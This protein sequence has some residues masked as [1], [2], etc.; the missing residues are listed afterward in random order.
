MTAWEQAIALSSQDWHLGLWE[1][2]SLQAEKWLLSNA[3][4]CTRLACRPPCATTRLLSRYGGLCLL[5]LSMLV[6]A[7]LAS[8]PVTFMHACQ[9]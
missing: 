8:P 6:F 3:T 5:M 7:G 9:V 1:F 2:Q 4:Y